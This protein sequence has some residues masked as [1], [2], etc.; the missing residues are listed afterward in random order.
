VR[1]YLLF[2]DTETSGLPPKWDVPYSER[3]NWPYSVQ[4][5]WVIFSRDG[6]AIKKESHYIKD[7]DFEISAAAFRIHGI[8]KDFL[9][10][11]GE[12]R[13][14]ILQQ[15]AADL[16]QYQ[17]LVIA[18][19]MQLDFHMVGADFYRIGMDNPLKD[20]PRFCTMQATSKYVSNPK[21]K[22]LRLDRLYY[23]L[24]GEVLENQHEALTDATATAAC[25]FE[26]VKLGDID[27]AKIARQQNEQKALLHPSP[28]ISGLGC[29]ISVLFISFIT[30]LLSL[31]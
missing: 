8:S 5:A 16:T 15:L 12:S 25:F 7:N 24:F 6:Q 4:I 31:W 29:S 26:M 3:D 18:H 22:Y 21:S 27:D 17:P 30:Y 13:Q 19:F 2:I 23:I 1:D 28:R 11:H 20:L 14:K 10:Q 9:L